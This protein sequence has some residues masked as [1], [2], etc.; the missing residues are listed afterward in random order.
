M[1]T[2]AKTVSEL[3]KSIIRRAIETRQNKEK[4]KNM[5]AALE[6]LLNGKLEVTESV[7][8]IDNHLK[9]EKI[10]V[11][12]IRQ[13]HTNLANVD[14]ALLPEELKLLKLK[15]QNTITSPKYLKVTAYERN[16]QALESVGYA[17]E[18]VIRNLDFVLVECLEAKDPPI[19][20]NHFLLLCKS[21]GNCP[22]K[23]VGKFMTKLPKS[24]ESDRQLMNQLT[25]NHV[26]RMLELKYVCEICRE[27][28]TE[29][30]FKTFEEIRVHLEIHKVLS[31]GESEIRGPKRTR[32]NL[33]DVD[34]DYVVEEDSTND[35]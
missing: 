22:A 17:R 29:C 11:D 33:R 12:H 4:L 32:Y 31:K 30:D 35:E 21:R 10:Y 8:T 7:E 27:M 18:L 34:T 24:L 23:L 2:P 19:T 20:R 16:D 6:D 15:E 13:S 5:T 1:L 14:Q 28:N 3:N 25:M 9:S 26:E